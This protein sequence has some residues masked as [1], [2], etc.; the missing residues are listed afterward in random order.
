MQRL[1]SQ[2]ALPLMADESCAIPSDIQR[3]HGAFHGVNIKLMKCG[4]ITPA[5]KMIR[6]ARNL[7]MKVMVGCM[8][9]SSIG[10]SA[11]A[12]LAPLLDCVDIDSIALLDR[13][14][15]TGVKLDH[16]RI[17]YPTKPGCGT[18]ILEW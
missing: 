13:D 9:E 8:P 15:A 18:E 4:G 12:Q 11:I 7:N 10:V 3:C 2:C 6:I 1:Y 17:V 16:G 14:I 5:R